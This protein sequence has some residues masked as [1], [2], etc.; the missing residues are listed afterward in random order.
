MWYVTDLKCGMILSCAV[1]IPDRV[2]CELCLKTRLCGFCNFKS[3]E[4]KRLYMSYTDG[5]READDEVEEFLSSTY[6]Y[7]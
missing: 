6:M 4:A 5:N 2:F 1:V 3:Q 7:V